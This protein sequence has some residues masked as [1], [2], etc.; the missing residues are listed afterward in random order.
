[1]KITI[2][3]FYCCRPPRIHISSHHFEIFMACVLPSI[4][5]KFPSYRH[6]S[7]FLFFF[8]TRT[9]SRI[10]SRFSHNTITTDFVQSLSFFFIMYFSFTHPVVNVNATWSKYFKTKYRRDNVKKTTT[11]TETNSTIYLYTKP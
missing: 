1:M 2:L 6:I 9:H 3:L 7:F 4:Q 5:A 10:E 11:K 8:L